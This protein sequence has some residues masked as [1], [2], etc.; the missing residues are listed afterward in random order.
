MFIRRCLQSDHDVKFVSIYAV[1]EGCMKSGLGHN[2]IACSEN[3]N[4][5]VPFLINGGLSKVLVSRQLT[6][7]FHLAYLL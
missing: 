6:A 5:S 4:L 7:A 1:F 2:L 3:C